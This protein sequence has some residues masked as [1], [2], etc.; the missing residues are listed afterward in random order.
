MHVTNVCNDVLDKDSHLYLVTRLLWLV[1]GD[2]FSHAISI[3]LEYKVCICSEIV[4]APNNKA[5]HDMRTVQ[6]YKTTWLL[7]ASN[8]H[9]RSLLSYAL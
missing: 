6:L 5:I 1:E 3:C 4:A 9:V 2:P 7:M 8:A